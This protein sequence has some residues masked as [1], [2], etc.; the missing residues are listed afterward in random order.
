MSNTYM[1]GLFKITEKLEKTLG[2]LIYF[3]VEKVDVCIPMRNEVRRSL[4]SYKNADGNPDPAS[5]FPS[6]LDA[7]SSY[8]EIER[9][10]AE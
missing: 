3:F 6:Y 7:K 10:K 4:A 5:F 8:A 2:V 1:I 9:T